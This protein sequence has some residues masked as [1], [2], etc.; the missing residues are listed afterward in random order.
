MR[1]VSGGDLCRAALR[2]R[3]PARVPS[4]CARGRAAACGRHDPPPP[5]RPVSND[6]AGLQEELAKVAREIAKVLTSP[7][8]DTPAL[9]ELDRRAG[10]LR[11]RVREAYP[12]RPAPDCILHLG[13]R[14]LSGG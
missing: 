3:H 4:R 12:P 6:L 13:S 5:G 2:V 7:P 11:R 14:L 8:V 10:D 9:E 1:G